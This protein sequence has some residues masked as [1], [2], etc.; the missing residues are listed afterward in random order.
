MHLASISLSSSENVTCQPYI[1][2]LQAVQWY[3][4]HLNAACQLNGVG[5][6]QNR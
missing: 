2:H 5:A 4:G 6:W 3:N 1:Y